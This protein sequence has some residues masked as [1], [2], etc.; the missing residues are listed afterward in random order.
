MGTTR[1]TP[2]GVTDIFS[3]YVRQRQ[4]GHNQ[5]GTLEYLRPLLQRLRE[6]ARRQLVALIRSWESREGVKYRP[7]ER[8]ATFYNEEELLRSMPDEDL[9][10]LP[11]AD[12]PP[13]RPTPIYDVNRPLHPSVEQPAP[14]PDPG[15]LF[16]CP[17]CGHGNRPGEVYCY[18]CGGLLNANIGETRNLEPITD[19]LKQVGRTHFGRS[20]LLLLHVRGAERPVAVRMAETPE[21]ILGRNAT[22]SGA[23]RADVDLTP[24]G[25]AEQGVSRVHARLRYQDNTITLTDMGS[26]NHTYVNGQRLHAHEVRVL[27]DGDEV[28]LGRLVMRVVFQHQVRPLK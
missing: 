5:E 6:D 2:P 13:T 15:R 20:W 10:W 3:E 23:G 21:V 11:Q 17:Q 8:Q 16:Y 25:A 24:Y 12:P 27:A 9:S 7:P 4:R 22:G 19:E 14:G 28:R 26:V 1:P 18:Y